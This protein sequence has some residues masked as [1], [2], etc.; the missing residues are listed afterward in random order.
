MAIDAKKRKAGILLPVSALPS[1]YGI[2][3]FGF[4]AYQFVDFLEASG[5]SIWQILP[6]GPT[7]LYASPYQ[8]LSAFA[9]NPYFVDINALLEDDLLTF[10]DVESLDG[11]WGSDKTSVSY[12]IQEKKKMSLLVKAAGKFNDKDL[13]FVEFKENNSDWLESYAMFRAVYALLDEE[14]L[15]TWEDKLRNPTSETF[16][17]IQEA[18]ADKIRSCMIIQY[19][20]FTQWKELKAYANAKG[21]SIVGDIPLYVAENSSDFWIDR[22]L[23]DVDCDGIPHSTAGVPP[24]AF[25]EDGQ[26]WN[27]PIYAWKTKNEELIEWWHKRI[28]QA[29]E[30]YDG[31]RIDHFRGLSEYYSIPIVDGNADVSKGKWLDGP[32]KNFIDMMKK[33]FPDLMI[34]AEDLGIIDCATRE[35]LAYSGYPGMKVLQFAFAGNPDNEYLPHNHIKNTVVYTGTHDNNTIKG[36][37]KSADV[38]EVEYARGY[39]GVKRNSNLVDAFIK[40]ALSSVADTAIVPMQDW[41]GLGGNA[42]FNIPSTVGGLNWKWRMSKDFLTPALAEYIALSTKNSDR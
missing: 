6:I 3:D 28:A 39:F 37:V 38:A 5:Q 18:F 35:L 19:F 10:E 15:E 11:E 24:D 42:R 26:V 9:G 1:E 14:P 31:I 8:C 29:A 13:D 36:W 25:S 22:E 2:G 16:A 4:G 32:G 33:D 17:E 30:L 12:E 7:G 23:F 27:T 21:I 34:I 41:L 40:S 20:F